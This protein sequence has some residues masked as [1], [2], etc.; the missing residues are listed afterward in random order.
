MVTYPNQKI[1]HINKGE[2]TQNY[3]TVGIDE[4]IEASKVLKP[5]TFK[6]YLY[7]CS[8]ADGFDL[9]LS[10]QDVINKLGISLDSYK[11]AIKELTDKKYIELKQGNV[12]DFYTMPSMVAQKQP[13]NNIGS[14]EAPSMGAYKQP[15]QVHT[16]NHNECIEAP[17]M[18]AHK[19]PE[20][21]KKN[22]IN[23][24]NT[25]NAAFGSTIPGNTTT[26][27]TTTT[28][29]ET[30]L[31]KESAWNN[32]YKQEGTAKG[33]FENFVTLKMTAEDARKEFLSKVSTP[34]DAAKKAFKEIYG[35]DLI[36]TDDDDDD[37]DKDKDNGKY[38]SS[39]Y[40]IIDA[41]KNHD[42]DPST[43]VYFMLDALSKAAR[44]TGIDIG[45]IGA[46]FSG[47]TV[48]DD[49]QNSLWNQRRSKMFE[50]EMTSELNKQEGTDKEME[51][52]TALENLKKLGFENE[53]SNSMLEASRRLKDAAKR[54]ERKGNQALA[55]LYYTISSSAASG[56]I[57]VEE[58]A[59]IAAAGVLDSKEGQKALEGIKE[60]LSTLTSTANNA[61]TGVN[62]TLAGINKTVETFNNGL[63]SLTSWV[64][65]KLKK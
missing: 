40:G 10:R 22:N 41:M 16:S 6:V 54:F 27:N 14:I 60:I 57:D 30:T 12:Y 28:A 35:V 51:Y 31:T 61:L 2:Y 15:L 21:N 37:D 64:S 19:P 13:L 20:I 52:K 25:N 9:A 43:G 5:N 4:W 24:I 56:K 36:V 55:D 33:L 29:P 39:M 58:I 53:Q 17:S 23:N 44:N 38:K 50:N 3:L 26:G 46:Q 48:R 59:G 11:R 63:S 7:L 32:Y 49:Y 47:G 18:V 1:I 62:N 45:N 8:N 65:D 34:S 42:I